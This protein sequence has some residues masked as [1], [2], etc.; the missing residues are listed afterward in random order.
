MIE[1]KQWTRGSDSIPTVD[2]RELHKA[3]A[4]GRDFST[5]ITT[6][7]ASFGFVEGEDF[8]SYLVERGTGTA[9][10]EYLLSVPM[11]SELCLL[12]R[13]EQGM[14]LRRYII[15]RKPPH[16]CTCACGSCGDNNSMWDLTT[17]RAKPKSLA[18]KGWIECLIDR[19]GD[20]TLTIPGSYGRV[21]TFR[22]NK[23]GHAIAQI[24]D[25]THRTN[26]LKSIFYRP[27][28]EPVQKLAL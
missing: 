25:P 8:T 28:V 11:S 4:P 23:Y 15:A 26:I 1:F 12:D 16:K 19:V 22:K 10:K 6:R 3:L 13:S 2:G 14:A 18:D 7:I 27:Y 17:E 5:W 9:A 24:D 21:V 20:T